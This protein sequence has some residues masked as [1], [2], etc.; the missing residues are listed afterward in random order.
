MDTLERE[1]DGPDLWAQGYFCAVA[2][3]I[4]M[5][6]GVSTSARELLDAAGGDPSSADVADLDT[7]RRHGLLDS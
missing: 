7:F 3:L 5:E 1:G 6:G 2:T 4:E